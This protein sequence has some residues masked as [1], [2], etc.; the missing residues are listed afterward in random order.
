MCPAAPRA[1]RN[2]LP[3]KAITRRPS[4]AL[5]RH[6]IHAPSESGARGCRTPSAVAPSRRTRCG[7]KVMRMLALQRFSRQSV[8]GISIIDALKPCPLQRHADT[9]RSHHQAADFDSV[10]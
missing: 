1:P 7:Q 6:H 3:S 4:M 8:I 5:V 2:A 10:L 9:P